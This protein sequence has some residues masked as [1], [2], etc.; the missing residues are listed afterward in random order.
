MRKI[1]DS[2]SRAKIVRGAAEPH[3]GTAYALESANRDRTGLTG[4][5]GNRGMQRLLSV[6]SSANRAQDTLAASQ[7]ARI[8][9]GGQALDAG[10]RAH[11]ERS[12]ATDLS[13]VR[14]HTDAGAASAAESLNA[15]AYAAGRD[16]VFGAGRYRPTTTE[17]KHLL[18]HEIAHTLQQGGQDAAGTRLPVPAAVSSHEREADHAADAV[19]AGGSARVQSHAGQPSIARKPKEG[20]NNAILAWFRRRGLRPSLSPLPP[21]QALTRLIRERAIRGARKL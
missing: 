15:D 19:A 20:L 5:L 11:F 9:S 1:T 10:I 12:F 17:G 2:K 8:P 18:A 4:T 14:I 21:D 16:I 3:A 6:Q 7:I 13:N